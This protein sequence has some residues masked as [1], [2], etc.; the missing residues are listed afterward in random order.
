MKCLSLTVLSLLAVSAA[1]ADGTLAEL[2]QAGDR[3]AALEMIRAGADVNAAQ[4]DGTTPLHWA[5]YKVDRELTAELLARGAKPDVINNYGSSPLAE[6]VKVGDIVLVEMLLDAG[7]D[8]EAPNQ[9]G[10]TALMLAARAGALDVARLLV[11][12]GAAVNTRET[13]RGQTAIMW[14]A[15]ASAPDI[16]DLLLANGAD[17]HVRALANEWEAQITS[18]PRG[19]YRPTGGLTALLYA[20]RSGCAACVASILDAGAAIDQPSPD[21]VTPLMVALDNSRFDTARG[22]LE[23][24]ANPHTW[25]WWGRTALYVAVD[26][27]SYNARPGTEPV[28]AGNSTGLDLMRLLL[29]AGVNPNP[30]LN[31]HRPSRGG[32]IGRFA[33]DLLTTG[34]T[35]LLRAAISHDR[36]AIA[37]LL[38]HGALVDLPN[39]MG[40]TPLM[41]AAG[42]GVRRLNI[43]GEVEFRGDVE[44]RAIAALEVLLAA[45]ADVNARIVDNYGRTG[46]IARASQMTEREGQTALYGAV[47]FAWARV[48]AFLIDRGASVDIVDA[49]GRSPIDAALGAIGGRD[50]TVSTEIAEMLAKA[51]NPAG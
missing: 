11:G 39:V 28:E 7:A 47:K 44:S 48:V 22:L 17:V 51:R 21:G 50:N 23:R 25:D 37:L 6:A 8:F 24:G 15:D 45:G 19:Q 4:G 46:R 35:P 43:G 20:A 31:M 16:V 33:D 14:A 18:E 2:V 13:W 40:V 36:E 38:A 32:N 26:M 49:H 41:A 3:A 10:Q 27:N 5:V 34:A 1:R 12:R 29:E 9:D 42:V 30:Q